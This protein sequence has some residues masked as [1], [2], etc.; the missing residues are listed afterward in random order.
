MGEGD[1]QMRDYTKIEAWKKADDWRLKFIGL[2]ENFRKKKF[3][4]WSVSFAGR[5]TS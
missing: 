4:V 5:A 1:A 3:T 2:Q